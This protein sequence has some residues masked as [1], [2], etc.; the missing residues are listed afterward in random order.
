MKLQIVKKNIVNRKDY[1]ILK[2]IYL[3]VNSFLIKS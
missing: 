1:Y 2:W 3:L